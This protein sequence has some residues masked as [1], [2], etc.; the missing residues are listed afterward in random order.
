MMKIRTIV[1]VT[2]A[3]ITIAEGAVARDG[4]ID[5]RSRYGGAAAAVVDDNGNL[6]VPADYRT[7][8]Q[9]LGSWAVAKDDGAGSKEMHMV[10][11]SPGTIAAYRKDGRFPDGA[12]L[13]QE[14]FKTVTNRNREQCRYACRLVRH[15]ERRCRAICGEQALG[16]RVGVVLVRRSQSPEDDLHRL[17][18]GLSGLP[19]AGTAVRLDLHAR[20]SRANPI[21]GS[22]RR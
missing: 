15:G 12:V 21:S 18:H 13:V 4:D 9:V 16:R 5:A 1:A 3:A 2:C 17:H 6:H 11:A 22:W 19:R 14:V 8:Y 10:Y 20:L 7:T